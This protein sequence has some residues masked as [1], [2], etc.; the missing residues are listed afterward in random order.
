[1]W[2][3]WGGNF[4]TS[5]IRGSIGGMFDMIVRVMYV[6][7]GF[8]WQGIA[9]FSHMAL[10]ADFIDALAAEMDAV[11]YKVAS[12]LYSS[13][14]IWLVLAVGVVTAATQILRNGTKAA[15][16]KLGQT[17]LP[18]CLL[19]FFLARVANGYTVDFPTSSTT[20]PSTTTPTV[21]WSGSVPATTVPADRT[22]D[23]KFVPIRQ[24]GSSWQHLGLQY[25]IDAGLR[26]GP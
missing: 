26:S 15:V 22:F 7:A 10:T 2:S 21:V 24:V 11:Y 13:G 9:W 18:I 12:A 1:M 4:L 20:R 23:R 5:G 19:L 14:L 16:S 8:V 6:V 17:L 25:E 3:N